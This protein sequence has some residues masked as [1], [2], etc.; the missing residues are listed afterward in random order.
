MQEYQIVQLSDKTSWV[1]Y[2]KNNLFVVITNIFRLLSDP[3]LL[4]VVIRENRVSE[5][6]FWECLLVG[7]HSQVVSFLREV[8]AG[9]FDVTSQW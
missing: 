7:S 9:I 4:S 8:G 3:L 2:K 5:Y 1:V 6:I